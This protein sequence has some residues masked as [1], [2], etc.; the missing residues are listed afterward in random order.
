M[1]KGREEKKG[2]TEWETEEG[3][4]SKEDKAKSL[5][6]EGKCTLWDA[7]P[8]RRNEYISRFHLITHCARWGEFFTGSYIL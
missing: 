8:R 3:D 4:G 7:D 1:W 6:L 2:A 5:K